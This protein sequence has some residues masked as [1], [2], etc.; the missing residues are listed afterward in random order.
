M[1]RKKVEGAEMSLGCQGVTQPQ[2]WWLTP[3]KDRPIL[4]ISE[5]VS[6]LHDE[7]P[8]LPPQ[9]FWPEQINLLALLG[10]SQA[11]SFAV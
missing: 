2:D 5:L 6:H 7:S 9:Y 8:G 4:L 10:I 3:Y 1:E 11:P